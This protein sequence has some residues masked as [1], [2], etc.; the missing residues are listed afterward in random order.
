[1]PYALIVLVKVTN[2]NNF[3]KVFVEMCMN[4]GLKWGLSIIVFE[5]SDLSEDPAKR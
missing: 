2:N 4:F 3:Q 5:C 1:M